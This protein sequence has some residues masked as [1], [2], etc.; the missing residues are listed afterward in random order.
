M[1][2]VWPELQLPPINLWN[3]WNMESPCKNQCIYEA[4]L[5]F[6][7]SC[8]RTIEEISNWNNQ[9]ASTRKKVSARAHKRL[10]EM[11]KRG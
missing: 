10:L 8:G 1:N 6:C 7:K 4:R 9:K 2:I 3:V 11:R 5:G